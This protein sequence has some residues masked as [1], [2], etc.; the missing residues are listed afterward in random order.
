MLDNQKLLDWKS[1]QKTAFGKRPFVARH[2]LHELEL[3]SDAE[4]I[5]VLKNHP[6]D[7]LQAFSMGT[8]ASNIHEWKPV[9]VGGASGRE[10]FSAIA[11]GRLWFHLFRMQNTSAQ[12]RDL[13]DRLFHELSDM[14]PN[15]TPVN[16]S[17]TLILSS[18]AA[19]VYYHADPQFNFL[20]HIRGSKRVWSYPAGDRDLIDQEMMEDIFASYADEEVPYKPEFDRKAKV[21]E[22][23]AGDVIWWP[24]NSPHRVTNLEGINVSLSTVYETEESY[25][26]KLVYCANRYFRRSWGIPMWSTKEGGVN[27]Y[28]KRTAFRLLQK[29]GAVHAPRRRAYVTDLRIDPAAPAGVA[30]IGGDPVLTEFSKREFTLTKNSVGDHVAVPALPNGIAKEGNSGSGHQ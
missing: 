22:L 2:R 16:R 14:H 4:L 28:I 8:D 1:E 24:L 30:K 13:L 23:N 17:A 15:F 12:Y 21:F 18:P 7:Q 20:W 25:R 3:F 6:R 19:L 11:R 9:D 5:Q 29:A 27:S 10:M 26:R